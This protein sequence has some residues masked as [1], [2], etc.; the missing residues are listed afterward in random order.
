[1]NLNKADQMPDQPRQTTDVETEAALNDAAPVNQ[2]KLPEGFGCAVNEYY[3]HYIAVADAKAAGFLTAALTMGAAAISLDPK[4]SWAWGFY[5][6]AVMLLS[7]SG[8]A[9]GTAI[10][11]RL[12]SANHRGL[13][14][15]ED[16]SAWPTAADYQR[17]LSQTSA[18]DV[19]CE[20]AA[21]NYVVSRVL[22]QKHVWV[23][24]SIL[25]FMV[26][27]AAAI[28]AFIAIRHG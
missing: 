14:F 6:A 5:W 10:I 25:F 23:R 12:P 17:A 7:A 8:L 4:T 22:H 16:V 18:Q 15:W 11:P 19:E 24:G 13:I 3:N 1:M 28:L 27:T 26:G 21:Q 20:Y 2:S 9:A